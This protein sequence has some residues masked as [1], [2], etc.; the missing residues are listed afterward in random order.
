MSPTAPCAPYKVLSFDCYGTLIDWEGGLARAAKQEMDLDDPSLL[1]EARAEAEWEILEQLESFVPYRQIVSQSLLEA[2]Q[3]TEL[4]LEPSQAEAIASS[5]GRWPPFEDSVEALSR[6]ARRFQL[7]IASNVDRM[8]LDG[9]LALLKAPFARCVTAED[10]KCYKPEP[11]HLMA[12][13]H[14]LELDEPE[15]LHVSAYPHYDLMTA[16]DLGI[17]V[18]FVNRH[19]LPLPEDLEPDWTARDLAD[20]ARQLGA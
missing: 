16:T 20:L 2:A 13:L 9:S 5:V 3:R 10:V 19:G 6:L 1:I 8:D 11:D 4:S 7:A 15:I 17:P 18:A 12:L 14:E